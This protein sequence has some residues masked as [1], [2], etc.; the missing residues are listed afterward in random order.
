MP[1]VS[2]EVIGAIAAGVIGFLFRLI[3]KDRAEARE[4]IFRVGVE[5]AYGVVSD[6]AKRTSNKIDDKAAL[7]L[8]VLRDFY[9]THNLKPSLADE[10]RAR[11]LFSAMHG[12][13]K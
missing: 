13:G 1:E 12:E 11:L 3:F 5:I 8:K 2:V 9:A 10:E 4:K 7:G 6:I